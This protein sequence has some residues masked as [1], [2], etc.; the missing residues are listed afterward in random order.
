MKLISYIGKNIFFRHGKK[1]VFFY[2]G[3]IPF[4]FKF[5]ID[6]DFECFINKRHSNWTSPLSQFKII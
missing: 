3:K 4:F 6:F 2:F 1:I 5:L